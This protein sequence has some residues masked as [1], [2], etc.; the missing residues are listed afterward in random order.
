MLGYK[1][2]GEILN[3]ID[4]SSCEEVVLETQDVKLVVRRKGAGGVSAATQE[5]GAAPTVPSPA[6]AASAP[7][8]PQAP[9]PTPD[10]PAAGTVRA[11]MVGTFYRAPSPDEP[12][13]V[14][15]GSTVTKGD[16]LCMIEVMKLF[17]TVHA[18]SDGVI[19]SIAAE[20]GQLVEFG[21][22]LFSIEPG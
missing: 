22:V 15:M 6:P 14:E 8:V 19:A 21:Q 10:E 3:L 16:P 11:P 1:E 7:P 9:A 12:P 4:S 13:F 2:V 18:E 5:A 17:T 20:N